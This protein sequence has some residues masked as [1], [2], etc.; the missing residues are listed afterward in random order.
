MTFFDDWCGQHKP[1][2]V[3]ATNESMNRELTEKVEKL[4]R[5]QKP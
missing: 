4:T 2:V 3:Y 1:A 5:R